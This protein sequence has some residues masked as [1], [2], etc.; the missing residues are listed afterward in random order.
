LSSARLQTVHALL[1]GYSS[2]SV[3]QL[4]KTLS[5]DFTH[6]VLPASLR[7]PTRDKQSFS[8]HAKG[9]FSVFDTFSMIPEEIYED[10]SQDVVVVHARMKGTLKH[11][12]QQWDNECF[13]S[14]HLT[15]D[16]REVLEVEE[17]VDSSKAL[18]MRMRHAP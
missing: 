5:P 4:L 15:S 8:L 14:V 9:I 18:E 11:T 2:L 16:G 12:K 1:D 3:P 10:A 17:F 6:R 7:M 13:M